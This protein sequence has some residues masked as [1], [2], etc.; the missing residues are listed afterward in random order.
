MTNDSWSGSEAAERQH[1]V[2]AVFRC[3]ENRKTML[4]STNSGLTCLITPDGTIQG[5]MEPFKMYWKL[6]DVPVYETSTYGTTVYTRTV[7][8]SA[9]ICVWLSYAIL[10]LGLVLVILKTVRKRKLSKTPSEQ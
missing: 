9:R 5:E 2:M 10:I 7:D 8:I 3:I 1:A 4:R 6:W